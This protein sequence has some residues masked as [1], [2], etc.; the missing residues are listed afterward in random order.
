METLSIYNQR[1]RVRAADFLVAKKKIEH[2]ICSRKTANKHRLEEI[3]LDGLWIDSMNC[4]D[5]SE[6]RTKF[7][8]RS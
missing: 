3:V 4:E 1:T 5:G 2:R 6:W 7:V 8:V